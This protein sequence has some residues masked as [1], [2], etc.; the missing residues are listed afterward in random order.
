MVRRQAA[1]IGTTIRIGAVTLRFI[2]KLKPIAED[3]V[4]DGA[5]KGMLGDLDAFEVGLVIKA[6]T[7]I[8]LY[9]HI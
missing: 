9:L 8:V 7:R 2:V 5:A 3:R 1:A 6:T 4:E